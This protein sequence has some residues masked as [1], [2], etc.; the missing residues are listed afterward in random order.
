MNC[1]KCGASCAEG[2]KFCIS[3]GTPI[4]QQ[5]APAAEPVAEPVAASV[6]APVAAAEAP[7]KKKSGFSFGGVMSELKNICKPVASKI[8]PFLKNKLVLAGIAATVLLLVVLCVVSI[9][10]SNDNGFIQLK[11]S[12]ILVEGEEEIT[13]LINN[14]A[15]KKTIKA[16]GYSNVQQSLDGKI[17]AFLAYEQGEDSWDRE[18]DLYIV[19]GNKFKMVAEDVVDFELSVS[20]K[21]LAYSVVEDED[22]RT[23][24]LYLMKVGSKKGKEVTTDMCNNNFV[25]S[26]DG[27]SVAYYEAGDEDEPNELYFAKGKNGKKVTSKETELLG[28][29]NNGKY[30]YAICGEEDS[31]EANLYKFNKKGDRV[32]LGKISDDDIMFNAD[33]TQV[34]F[35][36]DGKTYI[37]NKG[38]D[39]IKVANG[40]LR[41]VGVPNSGA[42]YSDD[43]TCPTDNLFN[44]VYTSYNEGSRSAILIKKNPDKNIKLASK[45]SGCTLDESGK[46]MY[47]LHDGEDLRVLKISHGNRAADKSKELAEDVDNFVVTSDRKRV[48]YISDDTLYSVNGKKGGRA[49]TIQSDDLSYSL[50]LNSKDVLF[51]EVE[52]DIYACSNGRTGKKVMSDADLAM[53]TA[54]GIVFATDDD[55]AIHANKTGK[56]FKFLLNVED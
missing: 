56:K 33:H 14:K 15:L 50:V 13:V 21:G 29:S 32:K 27:K 18:Y 54:N 30:I 43:A 3:C 5:A 31:S 42:A 28:I 17:T 19:K 47:Y 2:V 48:Y 1:P 40:E 20:G 10:K 55:K 44:H 34:M 24:G 41:I 25:I 4:A 7:A 52:G 16:D 23:Y 26:P 6:E 12:V 38:K 53:A 37:S 39:A 51:Y 36:N 46:Y 11:K 22:D 45:V 8:K 9:A 35:F 49:K